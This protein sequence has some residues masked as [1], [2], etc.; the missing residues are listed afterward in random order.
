MPLDD[1]YLPLEYKHTLS[2]GMS[3]DEYIEI[4]NKLTNVRSYTFNW[5][6]KKALKSFKNSYIFNRDGA[7][8]TLDISNPKEMSII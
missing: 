3:C 8:S 1:H 4:F 2:F 7:L 6:K 5:S